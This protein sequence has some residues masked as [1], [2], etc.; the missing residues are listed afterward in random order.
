MSVKS[1]EKESEGVDCKRIKW[2][3]IVLAS[4]IKLTKRVLS[5]DRMIKKKG[6]N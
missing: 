3:K 5:K 2:Q 1:R 6:Y 4:S